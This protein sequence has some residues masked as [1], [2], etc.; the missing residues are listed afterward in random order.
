M[1]PDINEL[2]ERSRKDIERGYTTIGPHRDDIEIY[3]NGINGKKF[4]S[5]GQQRTIALCLKLAE[6]EFIKEKVGEYPIL[7]LDDVLSELDKKRKNKLLEIIG[8]NI[9][10]FITTTDLNDIN[11]K[12]L[13]KGKI[14]QI[15]EGRIV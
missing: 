10:T 8:D 15:K 12:L 6:I 4:A 9:Q 11:D 1:T 7:L 5:Q 3:I 14:I 13:K 2:K